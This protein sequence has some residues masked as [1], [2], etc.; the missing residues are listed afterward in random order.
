MRVFGGTGY[1]SPALR[2]Y[3][4]QWGICLIT[5]DRWPAPLLASDTTS[6]PDAAPDRL[7]RRYLAWLARPQSAVLCTAAR[8]QLVASQGPHPTPRS[9]TSS[10]STTDGPMRCGA[11]STFAPGSFEQWVHAT[12]PWG[13][14]SMTRCWRCDAEIS[15]WEE[16]EAE[17]L[18]VTPCWCDGVPRG[19]SRTLAN[20]G[21]RRAVLTPISHSPSRPTTL[22]GSS[23]RYTTAT[24]ATRSTLRCHPTSGSA[25]A[26]ARSTGSPAMD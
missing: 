12:I 3:A 5:T 1:V 24:L 11:G 22:S 13:I 8:R 9:T 20:F 25:G 14:G 17:R 18:G 15:A 7:T 23:P 6:W 26:A 16:R 4:A 19:V 2:C 10:H 21:V